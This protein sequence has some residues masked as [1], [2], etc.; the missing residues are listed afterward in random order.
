MSERVSCHRICAVLVV[1]AGAVAAAVAHPIP[2]SYVDVMLGSD[3]IECRVTAHVIDLAHE[4]GIA[5]PRQL[6]QPDALDR[7]AIA[8]LVAGRLQILADG[9]ALA[10]ESRGVDPL[11]DRESV[12]VRLHLA[13]RA[14]PAKV[15][16]RSRLFPYDPNHRTFLNLYESGELAR[17]EIFDSEGGELD[18]F[19]RTRQGKAAAAMK[20]LGAGVEHIFIG[21]DHVLF[22]VGLLLAGGSLKRLLTIVTAFTAAHSVTLALTALDVLHPPPR[23]VEPAIA[24]SIVYVGLDN[25]MAGKGAR[26]VRAWIALGFGLVHGFGFAGVL[27]ELGLPRDHL[28][29]SLAAFNAGVEV[30]QACIV[31]AVAPLVALVA[32]RSAAASKRLLTIGSAA[33]CA[34][35]A[36]WFVERLLAG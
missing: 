20:F 1:V 18:Y 16:I 10:A 25:L 2:F 11:P 3:G 33:V 30:G 14:T 21:A 7:G 13:W 26:D 17:Q 23:L 12:G 32:R 24:L 31:L 8:G 27:R 22:V 35:G 19:T 5:E 15:S 6:L 34:A 4:L 36:Y 29:W 28:G 9:A